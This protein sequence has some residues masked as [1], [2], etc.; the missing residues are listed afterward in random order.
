MILNI[1][2]PTHLCDCNYNWFFFLYFINLMGMF[3]VDFSQLDSFPHFLMAIQHQ[4]FYIIIGA[5]LSSK[6]LWVS[7]LGKSEVWSS[8]AKLEMLFDHI[9][10]LFQLPRWWFQLREHTLM[11]S[12]WKWQFLALLPFT[13]YFNIFQIFPS[14]KWYHIIFMNPQIL[15][16]INESHIGK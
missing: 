15:L 9:F 8:Q 2:L 11:T 1:L 12:S 4:I 13:S 5:V 10:H 6:R 7:Y 3:I 14:P 16:K